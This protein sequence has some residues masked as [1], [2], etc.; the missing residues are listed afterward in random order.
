MLLCAAGDVA[1]V[2]RALLLCP[3]LA[4]TTD[5]VTLCTTLVCAVMRGSAALLGLLVDAGASLTARDCKG[6]DA[7]A[8]ASRF[9]NVEAIYFLI[10]RGMDPDL[11]DS[12]GQ[13]PLHHAV[14]GKHRHA[15]C[16]LLALGVNGGVRDAQGNTPLALAREVG[17]DSL[18]G[19]LVESSIASGSPSE[20]FFL[21]SCRHGDAPAVQA[22]LQRLPYLANARHPH[23][24]FTPLMTAALG[25]H[26]PILRL[27][28]AAGAALGGAPHGCGSSSSSSS[29][30]SGNASSAIYSGAW[31]AS[32][33]EWGATPSALMLACAEGLPACVLYLLSEAMASEEGLDAVLNARDERGST[34]LHHAVLGNRAPIVR[35]LLSVGA[36]LLANGKGLYPLQLAQEEATGAGDEVVLALGGRPW[37]D[38]PPQQ[39]QQQHKQQQHKQQQQGVFF[40]WGLLGSFL[41]GDSGDTAALCAT[42]NTASSVP[43]GAPAQQR[44]LRPGK[45]IPRSQSSG[46]HPA[47]A[48]APS[49]AP[50][51]AMELATSALQA[52]PH[53]QFSTTFLPPLQPQAHDTAAAATA[54]AGTVAAPPSLLAPSS[55]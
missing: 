51:A 7:L 14:Q 50:S 41:C 39:Q 6:M 22:L 28:R 47:P 2:S 32:Q 17:E 5:T 12:F 19:I 26:L 30:S 3:E 16:A 1:G 24:G 49:T 25:G 33:E 55:Q 36:Q 18:A 10:S 27:L 52:A 44:L 15:L 42:S 53:S 45:L 21:E 4:G 35:L 40:S 48:L 8:S 34:A 37:D 31:A 46:R 13:T 20:S 9:G 38:P 29:G 43:S 23:T 11:V 54:V